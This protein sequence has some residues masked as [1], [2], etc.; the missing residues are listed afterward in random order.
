MK[1]MNLKTLALN[2]AEILSA[3]EM[4]SVLRATTGGGNVNCSCGPG[5]GGTVMWCETVAVCI[6]VCEAYCET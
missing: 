6:E 4:K 3:K 1:K 2:G 5:G